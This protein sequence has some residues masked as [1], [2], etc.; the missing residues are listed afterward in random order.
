MRVLLFA[1]FFLSSL[2][3]VLAAPSAVQQRD[4]EGELTGL[5]LL[6]TMTHN[7]IY[8]SVVQNIESAADNLFS[9]NS[10]S[11]GGRTYPVILK[12]FTVGSIL[13]EATPIGS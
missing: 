3:A 6:G 4:N 13:S 9:I 12:R 7:T 10:K 5:S 8:L 2:F 11:S 1:A